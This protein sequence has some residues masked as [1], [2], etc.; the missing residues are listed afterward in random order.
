M[1]VVEWM[2]IFGR[3]PVRRDSRLAFDAQDWMEDE[4]MSLP[5]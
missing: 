5:S 1:R 3:Q 2:S 4:R